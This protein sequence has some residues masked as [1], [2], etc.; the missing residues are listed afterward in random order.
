MSSAKIT[1]GA[2]PSRRLVMK[3]FVKQ[4]MQLLDDNHTKLLIKKIAAEKDL[5]HIKDQLTMHEGAVLYLKQI[6]NEWTIYENDTIKLRAAEEN[7]R[8]EKIK[9]QEEQEKMRKEQKKLKRKRKGKKK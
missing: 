1:P 3:E 8:I 6:F 4:R 9:E 2:T 5:E 7:A